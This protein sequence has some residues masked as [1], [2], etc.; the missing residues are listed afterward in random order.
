[1]QYDDDGWND[2]GGYRGGGG[3][4]SGGGGGGG[5][6]NDRGGGRYN[7]RGGGRYNDRGR[8]GGRGGGYGGGYGGGGRGGGGYGGGGGGGGGGYGRRSAAYER[9]PGD[10]AEVDVARVEE[11]IEQ[12]SDFRRQRDFNAADEIREQLR[13]ELGVEVYDREQQWSVGEGG[14]WTGE[15]GGNSGGR[16]NSRDDGYGGG[17]GGGMRRGGGGGGGAYYEREAG[18]TAPIDVARVEELLA[19]RSELRRARDFQGA[20]EIR[21]E[22]RGMDVTVKDQDGIWFVGRGARG[23]RDDGDGY[24]RGGDSSWEDRPVRDFGP[25]GHDYEREG[26]EAEAG[27]EPALSEEQVTLI[28]E[29]IARRLAARLTRQFDV[30]DTTKAELGRLGVYMDDKRR[31]WRFDP[32]KDY[33]PLGHDY[34][35]A[36]EDSTPF[37]EGQLET[38]N[39]LLRRRMEAKMTKR[40]DVADEC[41]EEL[42]DTFNI[43]VNDKLRGWRADGL[44]FPTHQRVEG[45]GDDVEELVANLDEA[46]VMEILAARSLA[47]KEGEYDEADSLVKELRETYS[48][49]LEDKMGTWRL[50]VQSAG[51]YRVGPRVDPETATKVQD[52]LTRRS[53]HQAA[54]EYEEA[55]ALYSE[56]SELGISLDT[57]LKTW[58]LGSKDRGGNNRGRGGGNNRGRGGGGGYGRGGGGGYG[59]GGGGGYGRGGG[60]GY[61][62]GGNSRG[63]W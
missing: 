10:V 62:R 9:A 61:G 53:A 40:F 33:G 27:G 55:D 22:L 2:G 44:A 38:I 49:A 47:K 59:R 58:R 5:G 56:L 57:R 63:R 51:Y 23:G 20:D 60:G 50:V 37:D 7:D 39:D 25:R 16:Y 4:Y 36:E 29:L 35:R 24:S 54:E 8:G 52:L 17:G 31:T 12:R 6:Y 19:Q 21:D 32:P 14:D 3:G 28:D 48:V 46:R 26:G 45:D 30:A 34:E 13:N 15:Y 43:F 42:K 18:D 1:M 41:L 11:L